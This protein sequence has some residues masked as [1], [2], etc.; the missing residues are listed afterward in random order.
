MVIYLRLRS[1]GTPCWRPVEA[2]PVQEGSYRI[3]SK[4]PDDEEWP[5]ATGEVVRCE[6]QRF[7]DGFE[8]LV[9]VLPPTNLPPIY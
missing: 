4:K 5:V 3:L 6:L 1:E 2:E 7:S 9:I 8:G